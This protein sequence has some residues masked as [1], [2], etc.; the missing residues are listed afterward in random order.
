[1]WDSKLLMDWENDKCEISNLALAPVMNRA[2]NVKENF[3]KKSFNNIDVRF[4]T[5][6]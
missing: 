4:Q 2:L 1:M 6:L 5:W 3:E